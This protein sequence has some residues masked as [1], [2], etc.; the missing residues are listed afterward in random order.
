[1]NELFI[2]LLAALSPAIILAI[3]MIRKDKGSPEPNRWLWTAVG[4]GVLIGPI[5]ILLAYLGWPVFL[6]KIP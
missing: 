6:R 2:K 1:M 3:M 4:L 5:L